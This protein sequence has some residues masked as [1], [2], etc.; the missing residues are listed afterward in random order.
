MSRRVSVFLWEMKIQQTM[1]DMW[2]G[3]LNSRICIN[4][5]GQ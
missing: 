5:N 3:R 2:A 1:Y 4:L